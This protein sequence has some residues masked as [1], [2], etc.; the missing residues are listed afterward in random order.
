MI[1]F[2]HWVLS[3]WFLISKRL[4]SPSITLTFFLSQTHYLYLL[5]VLC[6]HPLPTICHVLWALSFQCCFLRNLPSQYILFHMQKDED[7]SG[8]CT[9]HVVIW[10]YCL[11]LESFSCFLIW[12]HWGQEV[13][14][15]A[16]GQQVRARYLLREM[17]GIYICF[18][19]LDESE[20]SI[21]NR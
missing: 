14:F 19:Y 18:G 6:H 1:S 8:Y 4:W 13:C 15:K 20:N 5:R 10:A 12:V 11:V 7:S 3:A 17:I 21:R 16:L 2:T 9:T